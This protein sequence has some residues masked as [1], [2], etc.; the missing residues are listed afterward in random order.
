MS[1]T[2]NQCSPTNA[3]FPGVAFPCGPADL[4]RD[5]Q[6]LKG[7]TWRR[8]SATLNSTVL[9]CGLLALPMPILAKDKEKADAGLKNAVVLIIRHAEKP[10]KG[11][12]LSKAGKKRAEA[13]VKYF[14]NYAVDS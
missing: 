3:A 10:D 7:A 13:Y 8:G 1:E 12:D 9:L 14:E 11:E 6:G 4:G 2:E 5:E